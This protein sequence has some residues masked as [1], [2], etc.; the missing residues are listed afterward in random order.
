MTLR[1]G[2]RRKNILIVGLLIL[3]ALMGIGYTA[4]SSSLKISGTSSV[5]T[6]WNISI[7]DISISNKIGSASVNGTPTYDGLTASFNTNLVLPGDSITYDIK[8]ENKGNLNAKLNKIALDKTD[9]PAI[10][11]S[12][13]GL[14]E[15]GILKQ[16]ESTI[17]HV[18]VTYSNGVTMQPTNL[19]A[20]LTVTLN[21]AQSDGT[22]DVP[23]TT[24][25]KSIDDLKALT[26]STGDGLYIDSTENGRYVYRGASPDN[27]IKL[28]DD[29][30]RI[31]A[32]ESDDTL[33]VMK[34]DFLINQRY[35]DTYN[36]NAGNTSQIR[37][38]SDTDDYCYNDN[39]A[40]Y[41]GCNIWGSK[42][43]TLDFYE[44]NVTAMIKDDT[45]KKYNLPGIEA[46]LNIYLN[47][48]F[49][50]NLTDNVKRIIVSHIFNVGPTDYGKN[51]SLSDN[52]V[53][54][55]KYKWKGKVGLVS[56]TDYVKANSNTKLCNNIYANSWHSDNLN[57]C[58]KTNFIFS[59]SKGKNWTITPSS[60]NNY[61]VYVIKG[62]N[63]GLNYAIGTDNNLGVAPV[64]FLNSNISLL[65]TG[66]STDPYVVTS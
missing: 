16:G 21:F 60:D 34:N 4:F 65:G 45:N 39:S 47:N 63:N 15:E 17:F 52:C 61:G 5:S 33:K 37:H 66:T 49:Y 13:S 35:D 3:L 28:D 57:I 36:Y 62:Y 54:E 42:T 31:I 46:S 38:S 1:R 58:N 6:S 32:I 59:I 7:T 23:I 41:A 26:T 29:M 9:N 18:M 55:K 51:I 12:T 22:N 24:S 53:D 43:T 48:T 8:V 40:G 14:K 30:Y 44:N 11:F 56:V 19:D 50:T 10:V 25:G 20:S 2:Y 64:F 27:Y